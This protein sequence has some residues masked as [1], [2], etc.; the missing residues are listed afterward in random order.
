MVQEGRDGHLLQ[1]QET[2]ADGSVRILD[3]YEKLAAQD[4]IVQVGT[5]TGTDL[6]SSSI[7][8]KGEVKKETG[9]SVSLPETGDQVGLDATLAAMGILGLAA[10]VGEKKRKKF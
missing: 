1:L 5:R 8:E 9:Q 2:A 6:A 4:E 7:V 10:L 3:R